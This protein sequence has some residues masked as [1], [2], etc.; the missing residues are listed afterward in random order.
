MTIFPVA[1]IFAK[2]ATISASTSCVCYRSCWHTD[3]H[4]LSS[5]DLNTNDCLAIHCR[6]TEYSTVNT[7]NCLR[8]RLWPSIVHFISEIVHCRSFGMHSTKPETNW[9]L[10]YLSCGNA[11][12]CGTYSVSNDGTLDSVC[13]MLVALWNGSRWFV[14]KIYIQRWIGATSVVLTNT[15]LLVYCQ[16]T[17]SEVIKHL[18]WLP[19]RRRMIYKMSNLTAQTLSLMPLVYLHSRLSPAKRLDSFERPLFMFWA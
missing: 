17:K 8:L 2:A 5:S 11:Y 6:I 3:I 4:V 19:L 12:Q 13:K 18:R 7:R 10:I 16:V 14:H 9:Q 1:F 15:T